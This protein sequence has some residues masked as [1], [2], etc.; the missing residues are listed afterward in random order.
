MFFTLYLGM[1][2][3]VALCVCSKCAY[4]SK[5]SDTFHSGV[6]YMYIAR[7]CLTLFISSWW[8]Q[9][10]WSVLAWFPFLNSMNLGSSQI[11]SICLLIIYYLS[12][13]WEVLMCFHVLRIWNPLR[14]CNHNTN[15][16]RTLFL[17]P[18]LS[19]LKPSKFRVPIHKDYCMER[20]FG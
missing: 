8:R 19:K 14:L 6:F 10:T 11:V 4:I 1:E 13:L 9:W 12:V 20:W 3:A 17:L 7:T 18:P 16:E 2:V 5:P 15:P